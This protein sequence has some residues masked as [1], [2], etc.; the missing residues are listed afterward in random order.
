MNEDDRGMIAIFGIIGIIFLVGI[1]SFVSENWDSIVR[2][3]GGI[4]VGGAAIFI[5]GASTQGNSTA[6]NIMGG[7]YFLGILFAVVVSYLKYGLSS[8]LILHGALSWVY[9]LLLR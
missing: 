7:L 3:V 5:I 8:W 1:L 2:I 9:I 6:E 4:I